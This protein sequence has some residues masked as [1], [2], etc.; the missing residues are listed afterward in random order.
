M[1]MLNKCLLAGA[2]TAVVA[3]AVAFAP[4][5]VSAAAGTDSGPVAKKAERK[6][7]CTKCRQVFTFDGPGNYKCP[8][9]N[10]PLIPAN[11]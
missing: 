6:Y 3:A 4:V 9:C 5:A 2:C 1:K 8:N 7:R 11:R 10:K